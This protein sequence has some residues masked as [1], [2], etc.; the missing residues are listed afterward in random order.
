MTAGSCLVALV[1]LPLNTREMNLRITST[2]Q[3]TRVRCGKNVDFT[4]SAWLFMDFAYYR[5]VQPEEFAN[6]AANV[7]A[8]RREA[9]AYAAFCVVIKQP[10][11]SS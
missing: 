9:E 7:C 10:E 3:T 6:L 4:G 11:D 1:F 5:L 8:A 2:D